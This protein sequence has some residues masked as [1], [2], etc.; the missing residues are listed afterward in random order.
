MWWE[1]RAASAWQGQRGSPGLVGRAVP[2]PARRLPRPSAVG[3]ARGLTVD[4]ATGGSDHCLL[5]TA[6]TIVPADTFRVVADL[7]GDGVADTFGYTRERPWHTVHARFSRRDT[8]W[9]AQP[10]VGLDEVFADWNKEIWAWAH[11]QKPDSAEALQLYDRHRIHPDNVEHAPIMVYGGRL[12]VMWF[13][14]PRYPAGINTYDACGRLLS[15][16]VHPGHLRAL[17][18]VKYRGERWVVFGGTNNLLDAQAAAREKRTRLNLPIVGAMLL[19]KDGLHESFRARAGQPGVGFVSRDLP[20]WI[21]D[22]D[23]NS[24]VV[25]LRQGESDWIEGT[26]EPGS[27][28]SGGRMEEPCLFHISLISFLASRDTIAH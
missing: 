21:A 5:D 18:P 9:T 26:C 13:M 4:G 23:R 17:L 16:Y 19:G 3:Q 24:Q 15:R 27:T 7:D 14:E 12:V 6:L 25:Y 11:G 20:Y 22:R 8:S 28:R 1:R 2:S 10:G